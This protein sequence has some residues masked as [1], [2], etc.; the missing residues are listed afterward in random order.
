MII[1]KE[2]RG[3]AFTTEEQ[4]KDLG[5]SVIL[6]YYRE[7]RRLIDRSEVYAMNI[8]IKVFYKEDEDFVKEYEESAIIS[9]NKDVANQII[10]IFRINQVCPETLQ[11]V[12]EDLFSCQKEVIMV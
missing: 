11:E 6:K 8:K 4:E 1:E 2:Y 7:K 5:Y 9:T 12:Y 3:M 10:E